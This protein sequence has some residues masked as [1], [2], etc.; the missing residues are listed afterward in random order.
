M[1]AMIQEMTGM[2][3]VSLHHDISTVTGDEVVLLTLASSPPFRSP[4]RS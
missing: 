1:E 3:V 2:R 4:G